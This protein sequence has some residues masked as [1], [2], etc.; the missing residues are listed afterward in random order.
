MP[1]LHS[2]NK[3][4]RGEREVVRLLQPVVDS[5]YTSLGLKAPILQRNTLQ[6]DRGGFDIVGLEWLALE[7]KHHNKPQVAA[8]WTQTCAQAADGQV[9]LLLWRLTGA[10][11]WSA[12]LWANLGC[13]VWAPA[14]VDEEALL[15]WFSKTLHAYLRMDNRV[16]EKL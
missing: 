7:V 3:G 16:K 2:R 5:V 13:G 8:W 9:P 10:R 12:R 1:G 14:T 4:K 11:S 15:V 6:S